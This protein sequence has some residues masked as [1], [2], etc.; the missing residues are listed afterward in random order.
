MPINGREDV[1]L[2]RSVD[3]CAINDADARAGNKDG[4]S[5]SIYDGPIT[6]MMIR[7]IPCRCSTEK[8]LDD[9]NALGYQGEY[10]FFYLPQTRKQSSNLGYA[11]INFKT[12]E[13]A[14]DFQLRMSGHKF[15]MSSRH[16]KSHKICCVA[17]ATIQGLENTKR[18]F[19]QSTVVQTSRAPCFLA[20]DGSMVALDF[21]NESQTQCLYDEEGSEPVAKGFILNADAAPF[22]PF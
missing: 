16:S 4:A 17:P 10:D 11:F 15:A 5:Y 19:A 22:Q 1:S 20:Q 7:N 14:A 6:T 2:E 21:E 13:V 12:P 9:I 18:H 3:Q 8:I